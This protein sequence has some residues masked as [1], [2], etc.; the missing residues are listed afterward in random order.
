MQLTLTNILVITALLAAFGIALSINY[1]SHKNTDEVKDILR[2]NKGFKCALFINLINLCKE[3]NNELLIDSINV[4][5]DL[6]FYLKNVKNKLM[7]P[8]R[9]F[10]VR[11]IKPLKVSTDTIYSAYDKLFYEFIDLNPEVINTYSHYIMNN[12]SEAQKI[13]EKAV[14][15]MKKYGEEDPDKDPELHPKE[16]T[17]SDHY[18]IEDSY[19]ISYT[20]LDEMGTTEYEE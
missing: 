5:Y 14:E 1:F 3:N 2:Y 9:E 7:G 16:N 8:Y 10:V 18:P 6:S 12:I 20:K 11:Y 4:S 15:D 13:E 17:V 19:T